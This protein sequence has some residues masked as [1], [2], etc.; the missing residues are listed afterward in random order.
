MNPTSQ[1]PKRSVERVGLGV[2][3]TGRRHASAVTA[4]SERRSAADW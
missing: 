2:F 3:V 1:A 4:R